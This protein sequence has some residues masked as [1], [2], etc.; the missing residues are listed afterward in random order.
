MDEK[1]IRAKSL[2]MAVLVTKI[3]QEA[4]PT[5][6]CSHIDDILY[7]AKIFENYIRNG[8]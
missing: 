3:K 6:D 5:T 7:R 1:E 8:E 4:R 2:E